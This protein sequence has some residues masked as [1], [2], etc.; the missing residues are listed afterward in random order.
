MLHFNANRLKSETVFTDD[1]GKGPGTPI[2]SWAAGVKGF[3]HKG[4]P[5][6][7]PMAVLEAHKQSE[8]RR[9]RRHHSQTLLVKSDQTL[10]VRFQK[11]PTQLNTAEHT[12]AISLN[13]SD[14]QR[15]GQCVAALRELQKILHL[16]K[17]TECGHT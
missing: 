15:V 7:K 14:G 8:A 9:F 16:K 12:E 6:L 11:H 17:K 1:L 5:R 2:V 4:P 10:S 13:I 3:T